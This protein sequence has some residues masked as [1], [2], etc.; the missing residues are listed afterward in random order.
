MNYDYLETRK[1]ER[2]P[3]VYIRL[4]HERKYYRCEYYDGMRILLDSIP[5]GKHR[6]ET[7]HLDFDMCHPVAIAPEGRPVIVN[8]CGT[9]VSDFAI[10]VDEEKRVMAIYY[11]GD[12]PFDHEKAKRYPIISKSTKEQT[13]GEW[14][15]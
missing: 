12:H 10:P 2:Q 4:K 8:F 15:R 11:S 9:I 13:I 14:E 7:R 6:Y 5:A 1:Y 3:Y